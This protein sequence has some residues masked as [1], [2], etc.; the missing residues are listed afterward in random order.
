MCLLNIFKWLH[1]RNNKKSGLERFPNSLY[2]YYAYNAT[3]NENRLRGEL[4]FSSPMRFND[5]FDAQHEVI[6]NSNEIGYRTA[7][8]RLKEIGFNNPESILEKLRNKDTGDEYKMIVRRKQIE[9]VGI[10]C[11]TNSP[12]NL[13]MWAYYGNNEGYCIEYDI[14]KL[15]ESIATKLEGLNLNPQ[16]RY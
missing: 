16:N 13:L 8:T 9:N 4:F 11:L 7:I 5:V 6:N 12:L 15:R 14:S 1:L 2:K 3:F 10:L